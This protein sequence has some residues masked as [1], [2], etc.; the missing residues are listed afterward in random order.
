MSKLPGPSASSWVWPTGG[1]SR[2]SLW[3]ESEAGSL[4]LPLPSRWVVVLLCL[5]SLFCGHS[6][7]QGALLGHSSHC[8]PEQQPLPWSFSPTHPLRCP[9]FFAGSPNPTCTFI[10]LSAVAPSTGP[11][12]L[13]PDAAEQASRL[14]QNGR[15]GG[16]L[17]GREACAVSPS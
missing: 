9:S 12:V 1:T 14:L 15:R 17:R 11:P 6:W 16:K 8:S 4:F 2:R 10:Q 13:C 3:E 5:C 7:G